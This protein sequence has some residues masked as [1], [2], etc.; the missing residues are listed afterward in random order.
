[1]LLLLITSLLTGLAVSIAVV[2]LFNMLLPVVEQVIRAQHASSRAWVE[3][4][5][6]RNVKPQQI[7]FLVISLIFSAGAF[8]WYFTG[9]W[10][11]GVTSAVAVLLFVRS[12]FTKSVVQHKRMINSQLPD[13]LMHLSANINA[14]IELPGAIEA[15]AKSLPMPIAYEI[16]RIDTNYKAG[17]DIARALGAVSRD[18][19]N[20]LFDLIVAA[21]LVGERYGGNLREILNRME[22]SFREIWRLEEKKVTVSVEANQT[23]KMLLMIGL[24]PIAMVYWFQPE[25][26]SEMVD[27]W[28]GVVVVIFAGIVGALGLVWLSRVQKIKI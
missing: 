8:F 12:L 19:D 14:G 27:S 13:F 9:T 6:L 2:I 18:L 22:Q 26:I 5:H 21:L 23:S 20:P 7:T 25:M 4:L 15:S 24:L 17:Q 3:T 1:M 16:Q 28:F 10:W 11:F